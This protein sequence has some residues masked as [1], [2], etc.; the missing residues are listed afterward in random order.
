MVTCTELAV[1][2]SLERLLKSLVLW[3]RSRSFHSALGGGLPGAF[4]GVFRKS[5]SMADSEGSR[6]LGQTCLKEGFWKMLSLWS[7]S[8]NRPTCEGEKA[9][10]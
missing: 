1:M 6:E 7:N 3:K 5:T 2:E 10:V 8:V 9:F 4:R